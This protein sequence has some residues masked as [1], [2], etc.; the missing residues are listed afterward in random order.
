MSYTWCHC[1]SCDANSPLSRSGVPTGVRFTKHAYKAHQLRVNR[2]ATDSLSEATDV[3]GDTTENLDEGAMQVF[4]TTILDEGPDLG[5]LPSKLWTTRNDFQASRASRAAPTCVQMSSAVQSLTDAVH[6]LTISPSPGRLAEQFERFH[7]SETP[8]LPGRLAE[9]LAEHFEEPHLSEI[10]APTTLCPTD[11]MRDQGIHQSRPAISY[12]V[13]DKKDRNQFTQSALRIV[14]S[15]ED[16]LNQCSEKL[17]GVPT[18]TI[19]QEVKTI[20]SQSREA[21]EKITRRTP[22]LDTRKSHVTQLLRNV[23]GRLLE[24]DIASPQ[25]TP[26]IYPTGRIF[27]LTL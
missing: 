4:T 22:S 20:V 26:L 25:N 2:E 21:L 12:K 3:T 18:I 17:S 11:D 14:D 5:Q 8:P 6:R 10:P 1:S 27:L 19:L 16:H 13:T 23:E 7:L 15:V 9:H 24:L